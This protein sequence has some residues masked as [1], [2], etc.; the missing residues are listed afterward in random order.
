MSPIAAKMGYAYD[1]G[2]VNASGVTVLVVFLLS[3]QLF[4]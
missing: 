1:M 2:L 4:I 3:C